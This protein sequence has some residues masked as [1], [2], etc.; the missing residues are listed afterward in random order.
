MPHRAMDAGE[1]R[2]QVKTV[3]AKQNPVLNTSFSAPPLGGPS[4]TR[5]CTSLGFK[6]EGEHIPT[7]I[8]VE[9]K[10]RM[11]HKNRSPT[12]NTLKNRRKRREKKMCKHLQ[13]QSELLPF[14]T[15]SLLSDLPSGSLLVNHLFSKSAFGLSDK[16][17][18]AENAIIFMRDLSRVESITDFTIAVVTFVKLCTKKPFCTLEKFE[19]LNR[20]A[21]KIYRLATSV[22]STNPFSSLAKL[23]DNYQAVKR[24]PIF[25][26]AYKLYVCALSTSVFSNCGLPFVEK[27]YHSIERELMKNVYEDGCDFTETVLRSSLFLCE[28]GYE[29]MKLGSLDPIFHSESSYD[30]WVTNAFELKKCTQKLANPEAFGFDRYEYLCNL[31]DAIDQGKTMVERARR[32][33]DFEV[34]LVRGLLGDLELIYNTEITKRAACR[35]RTPP[36]AV[37][38]FGDSSVGKSTFTKILFYYFG[39]LFDLNTADEFQYTRNPKDQFWSGFNSS[40]WSVVLDDIADVLPGSNASGDPSVVE[41][42]QVNNYTP[43]CP[44]QADLADKGRTP[45]LAKQIVATTNTK[46]LNAHA[47]FSCPLAVQRRMPWVVH[48]RVKEEYVKMGSMLDSTKV[49]PSQGYPDLWHIDVE[50]VEPDE[51]VEQDIHRRA[52]YVHHASYDNIN[53]FLA[54][55][56]KEAQAHEH[57]QGNIKDSYQAMKKL[58]ICKECCY[59]TLYCTCLK[60]QADDVESED[61]LQCVPYTDSQHIYHD[62]YQNESWFEFVMYSILQCILSYTFFRRFVFYILDFSLVNKSLSSLIFRSS[63][64]NQN[65]LLRIVGARAER[66]LNRSTTILEMIKVITII[67]SGTYLVKRTYQLFT[68]EKV[69][70]EQQT[71]ERPPQPSEYERPN[72]WYKDDYTVTTFDVSPQTTSWKRFKH[73]E[74]VQRFKTNCLTMDCGV[75]G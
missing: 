33:G 13:P 59:E 12:S 29:C 37:L 16:I 9:A 60:V 36:F 51:K 56:G 8:D 57:V 40:M 69:P 61:T 67:L 20:Y 62:E 24:C 38:L 43:L 4:K 70:D 31:K 22:Q 2:S 45:L 50:R 48:L 72:V 44:N 46:R 52:R 5:N 75:E 28:R 19:F 18:L 26:H 15:D 35:T 41:M 7:S 34:K 10:R 3:L 39:D 55:Y 66:F 47:Y 14:K 17:D 6:H 25:K 65:L 11:R 1:L 53:D 63:S 64:R 71:E 30:K 49:N 68:P 42:L 23:L 73:D 58:T 27:N 32:L 21:I 74:I 54:W